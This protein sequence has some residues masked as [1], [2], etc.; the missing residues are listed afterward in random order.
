MS[1]GVYLLTS[2]MT[3]VMVPSGV[4]CCLSYP[5]SSDIKACS[6]S[7]LPCLLTAKPLCELC[8]LRTVFLPPPCP[9]SLALGSYWSRLQVGWRRG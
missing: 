2:A 7:L 9:G 4:C 6:V 8:L 1:H 3:L 5:R